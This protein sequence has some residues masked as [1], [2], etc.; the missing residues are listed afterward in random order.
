MVLTSSS[1]LEKNEI[2]HILHLPPFLANIK[3]SGG[4]INV[5]ISYLPR[6]YAVIYNPHL[7]KLPFF[8]VDYLLQHINRVTFKINQRIIRPYL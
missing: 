5:P 2:S 7:P 1:Y 4:V 8:N 6:D 3:Y